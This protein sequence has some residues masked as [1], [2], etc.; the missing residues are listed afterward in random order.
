[1]NDWI[2]AIIPVLILTASFSYH[3][4]RNR[5]F[6]EGREYELDRAAQR[7]VRMKRFSDVQ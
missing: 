4:G 6:E 5:G 7:H 1:M 3:I 2:L